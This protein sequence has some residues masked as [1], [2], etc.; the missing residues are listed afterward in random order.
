MS[1]PPPQHLAAPLE[2]PATIAW[3][4]ALRAG[5]AAQRVA[6]ANLHALLLHAA[7]FEVA[8]RR[9][10]VPDVRARDLS[11]LATKAADQALVAVLE[12]LPDFHGASRF[13]TWA[14]KFA[15]ME[16]GVRLRQRAWEKRELP[17]SGGDASA[18]DSAVGRADNGAAH[19]LAAIRDCF[20]RELTAHERQ[21]LIA[22]AIDG[23]PIDVL[24]QRMGTTRGALY[25]ALHDARRRLRARLAERALTDR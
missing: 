24:A 10:T 3:L 20:D 19:E 5:G 23:V 11:A 25:E 15:L 16:A 21:V 22:L 14:S 13:T 2:E 12:A 7:R 6:I 18:L 4:A 1:A 8:R 9:T 17:L